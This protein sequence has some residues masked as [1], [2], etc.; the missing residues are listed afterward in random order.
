M[1]GLSKLRQE[2]NRFKVETLNIAYNPLPARELPD[3]DEFWDDTV[4][5]E[6]AYER[7]RC[8][9]LAQPIQS[10]LISLPWPTHANLH[11]LSNAGPRPRPL[12]QHWLVYYQRPFR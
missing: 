3:D 4:D 7:Y 8:G 9:V 12:L 2:H 1:S 11:A 5:S 10:A 6:P